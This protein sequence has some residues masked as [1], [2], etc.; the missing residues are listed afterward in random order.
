MHL[1]A[2]S[3]SAGSSVE[4]ETEARLCDRA[5]AGDRACFG[6]LVT[7]HARRVIV[8][9]LAEG[10]SL[11][12]AKDVTQEAWTRIWAERGQLLRLTLPGLAITQALFIARDLGR[13]ARISPTVNQELDTQVPAI[14]PLAEARL[15][16][17]QSLAR[18]RAKL[19]TLTERQRVVFELACGEGIPHAEIAKRCE[20][21]LQRVRQIIWE[22]RGQLRATLEESP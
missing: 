11:D 9:L 5:K 17:G 12:V 2:N 7:R 3:P 6:E 13:R 15:Q 18:V 8:T 10:L 21:S 1:V 20:I 16:S 4:E 22:V 14:I 19:A